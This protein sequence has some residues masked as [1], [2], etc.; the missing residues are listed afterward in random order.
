[1]PLSR[2]DISL[3]MESIERQLLSQHGRTRVERVS[4][5]DGAGGA[6]ERQL[7]RV[8]DAVLIVPVA[9]EDRL[10][11]IRNARIAA[12]EAI[13]EFPA[14]GLEDDEPLH[15]AAA[16]ELEEEAGVVAGSLVEIGS[17][18]TSPGLSDEVIT[19]FRASDLVER[20]QRLE[21]YEQIV[22]E[23]LDRSEVLAKIATGEIRDGKT[24]AALMLVQEYERANGS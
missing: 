23:S 4:W 15:A 3:S 6:Y 2:G 8:P 18:Y 13:W 19:V 14:G 24:I 10:L 16:R 5:T 1:M 22:V 12:G 17:F 11:L 7:I 21:S 9:A 20:S